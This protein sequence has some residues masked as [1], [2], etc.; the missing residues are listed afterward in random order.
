MLS[1]VFLYLSSHYWSDLLL[2]YEPVPPGISVG[3][4]TIS[5]DVAQ[6]SPRLVPPLIS[7]VFSVSTFAL[8][9]LFAFF[10]A[11]VRLQI[12]RR[13]NLA[14]DATYNSGFNASQHMVGQLLKGTFLDLG[15]TFVKGQSVIFYSTKDKAVTMPWIALDVCLFYVCS[16]TITFYK[17]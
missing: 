16:W 15:P 8:Q 14:T 1:L 13:F 5:N 3:V 12:S 4:Q 11:A 6:V 2:Y 17:T 7:R 10:S 9:I